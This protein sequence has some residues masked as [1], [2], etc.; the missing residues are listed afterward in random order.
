MAP[1][2][3]PTSLST[4]LPVND[5]P[6]EMEMGS[7][8]DEEEIRTGTT[9]PVDISRLGVDVRLSLNFVFVAPWYCAT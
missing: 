6:D 3:S 1:P 7:V 9:L 4:V 2:M 5:L 8:K